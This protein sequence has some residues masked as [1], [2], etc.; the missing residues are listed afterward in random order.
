MDK[1]SASNWQ[2]SLEN[3]PKEVFCCKSTFHFIQILSEEKIRQTAMFMCESAINQSILTN[4]V[5][6]VNKVF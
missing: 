4:F 5:Q 6:D 3:W 2:S 1:N